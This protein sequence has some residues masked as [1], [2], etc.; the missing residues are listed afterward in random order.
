MLQAVHNKALKQ[1]ER[2]GPSSS[3]VQLAESATNA[4]RAIHEILMY[5][6]QF[7]A[8][9]IHRLPFNYLPLLI[10]IFFWYLITCYNYCLPLK[11]E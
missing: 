7:M 1:Q 9:A 11:H 4:I 5:I 3:L 6:N 8:D 2:S 10:K